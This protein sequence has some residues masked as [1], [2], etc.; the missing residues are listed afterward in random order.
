MSSRAGDNSYLALLVTGI[1]DDLSIRP[2]IT[3]HHCPIYLVF[4]DRFLF[5]TGT[6]K[7]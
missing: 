7:K 3:N 6:W 2:I 4:A 1:K 5:V